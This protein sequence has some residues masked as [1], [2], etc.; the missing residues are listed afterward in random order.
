MAWRRAWQPTRYSCLEDLLDRG[1]RWTT[2]IGP[3]SRTRLKWLSAH[4]HTHT[5]T[6]LEVSL[7]EL[8]WPSQRSMCHH[9]LETVLEPP[10]P[11]VSDSGTLAWGPR[12]ACEE[13]PWCC[14]CWRGDF[15]ENCGSNTLPACS[16][17]LW[18]VARQAPASMGFSRRE[19]WSG[20]PFPPP[21]ALPTIAPV[22]RMMPNT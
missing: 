22:P 19:Y 1:A 21:S 18:T 7:K 5:H 3:Q 10:M 4:T 9:Q 13:V 2:S 11:G 16:V 12:G 17:T 8:P 20:L 15:F 14:C 6:P